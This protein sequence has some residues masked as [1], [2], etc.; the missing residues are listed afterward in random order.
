MLKVIRGRAR[1][2]LPWFLSV[3]SIVSEMTDFGLLLQ[4]QANMDAKHRD[5]VAFVRVCSGLSYCL[6]LKV[7]VLDWKLAKKP[8]GVESVFLDSIDVFNHHDISMRLF[9]QMNY[10]VDTHKLEL[11]CWWMQVSSRKA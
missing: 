5:K 2:H 9:F 7:A 10:Y 4:L 6:Q 11:C 8:S 3:L 1:F